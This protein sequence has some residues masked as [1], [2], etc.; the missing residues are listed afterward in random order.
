MMPRIFQKNNEILHL[1]RRGVDMWAI[2][3][4]INQRSCKVPYE[5]EGPVA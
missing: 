2:P 3:H 5:L 1:A 4:H